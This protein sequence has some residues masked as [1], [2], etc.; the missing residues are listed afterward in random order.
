MSEMFSKKDKD[1][2]VLRTKKRYEGYESLFNA[3]VSSVTN[4][5]DALGSVNDGIEGN[6][7]EI[8]AHQKELDSIK[9]DMLTSYNR[10][11][12]VI[13]NLKNLMGIEE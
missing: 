7:T 13:Q 10:N 8:E 12:K 4:A 3:A 9:S 2:V 11:L 6:I 5:I 1:V